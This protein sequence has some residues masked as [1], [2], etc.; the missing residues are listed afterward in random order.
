MNPSLCPTSICRFRRGSFSF[1]YSVRPGTPGAGLPRQIDEA[2]K[3]ERLK[4]LQD[5]LYTQQ[6][7]FNK[8][9]IGRTL[10]VLVEGTGRKGGQLFGRSPYLQGTHFDGPE[11]LIGTIVPV[12]ITDAGRNSLSGHWANGKELESTNNE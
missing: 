7:N 8:S 11:S 5:L 4:R 6:Q 12:T 2:V 9:L 10:D 1:K 3:S